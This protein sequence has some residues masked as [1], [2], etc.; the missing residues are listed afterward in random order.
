M[1]GEV[2]IHTYDLS[3]IPDESVTF[4]YIFPVGTTAVV[5]LTEEL[6]YSSCTKVSLFSKEVTSENQA[7][8]HLIELENG[9]MPD[10]CIE[11][12]FINFETQIPDFTY[13]YKTSTIDYNQIVFNIDY[14]FLTEEQITLAIKGQRCTTDYVDIQTVVPVRPNTGSSTHFTITIDMIPDQCAY[15]YLNVDLLENA[16]DNQYIIKYSVS[17][18]SSNLIA[19]DSKTLSYTQQEENPFSISFYLSYGDI[20]TDELAQTFDANKAINEKV[21]Y[22]PKRP[23]VCANQFIMTFNFNLTEF[24]LEYYFGSYINGE[25]LSNKEFYK[26]ENPLVITKDTKESL[27]FFATGLGCSRK[28]YK[29]FE[30]QPA[31]EIVFISDDDM[32]SSCFDFYEIRV[33]LQEDFDEKYFVILA[34]NISDSTVT[35]SKNDNS[36]TFHYYQPFTLSILISNGDVCQNYEIKTLIPFVNDPIEFEVINELIPDECIAYSEES[37]YDTINADKL[38]YINCKNAGSQLCYL[39]NLSAIQDSL[40]Y[41]I[42]KYKV[43]ENQWKQTSDLEEQISKANGFYIG[44]DDIRTDLT[45]IYNRK[46]IT[47][48]LICLT[49]SQNLLYSSQSQSIVSVVNIENINRNSYAFTNSIT[50][51]IIGSKGKS[52]SLYSLKGNI[53]HNNKYDDIYILN[54]LP[55]EFSVV[56]STQY[57]LIDSYTYAQ[58]ANTLTSPIGT[59]IYGLVLNEKLDSYNVYLS[60]EGIEIETNLV[61]LYPD[62]RIN[63][64]NDQIHCNQFS[65]ICNSHVVNLYFTQSAFESKRLNY[66]EQK[67]HTLENV[68]G[69]S[70]N[71]SFSHSS[72]DQSD[73][74][75]NFIGNEWE[76]VKFSNENHILV[77]SDNPNRTYINYEAVANIPIRVFDIS[78]RSNSIIFNAQESTSKLESEGGLIAGY[79]IVGIVSVSIIATI[80]VYFVMKAKA[81]HYYELDNISS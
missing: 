53:W 9:K 6:Y 59:S 12:Y 30:L 21:T 57:F 58:I 23:D 1:L 41:I 16:E 5:Y 62:H 56:S 46:Q 20:C 63:Q 43:L 22:T 73:Y 49:G 29:T 70:F 81:R 75:V 45:R 3:L 50:A 34:L 4:Q 48:I 27:S 2:D 76:N 69:Y 54:C 36:V 39:R 32:P 26:I 52:L 64:K 55:S 47:S 25:D 8:I 31:N 10:Q 33:A 78:N 67:K 35:L 28:Y 72:N 79:V 68:I 60:S 44:I 65:I 66:N 7:D 24:E 38:I 77:E 71:I 37:Y 40:H 14:T 15:Y 17:T 19:I 51:N 42:S 13:Y 11:K 61:S 18:D 74:F 80:V